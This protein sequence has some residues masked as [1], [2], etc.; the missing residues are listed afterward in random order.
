MG[1]ALIY[2]TKCS[3]LNLD[4]FIRSITGRP[5]RNGSVVERISKDPACWN[6]WH[7]WGAIPIVMQCEVNVLCLISLSQAD[8]EHFNTLPDCFSRFCRFLTFKNTRGGHRCITARDLSGWTREMG[9]SLRCCHA[10]RKLC[11]CLWR[12]RD[13]ICAHLPLIQMGFS[14]FFF[15]SQVCEVPSVYQQ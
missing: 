8:H 7:N 1:K 5:T 3:W 2:Y 12:H 6:D 14:S 9:D 13:L 15:K 10:T 11:A 4:W